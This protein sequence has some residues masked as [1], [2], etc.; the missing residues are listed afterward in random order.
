MRRT[1]ST[2]KIGYT[3]IDFNVTDHQTASTL[4]S[5]L[6][7][8]KSE[9]IEVNVDAVIDQARREGRLPPPMPPQRR[10]TP[11]TRLADL[12]QSAPS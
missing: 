12:L 10:Q 5:K 2:N 1:K 9:P 7:E 4:P 6:S 3:P 8:N 11:M